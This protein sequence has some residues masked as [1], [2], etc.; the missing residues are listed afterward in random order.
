MAKRYYRKLAMLHKVEAVYGTD[1]APTGMANAIQATDVTFT[2]ME[3]GEEQRDLLQAHFGHSGIILTGLHARLEF[4]VELAG[5]GTAGDVPAWGGL[6]R[7]CGFAE[8]VTEDTDVVY[9]PVSGDFES[10][11]IWYNRDGV[12]HAIVGQRGTVSLQM[13]PARIPRLRFNVLG[14]HGT[15][16]ADTALPTVDYTGFQ[17]PLVVSKANT[18]FALHG[19]SGPTESV[20]IDLGNQVEPRMLIGEEAVVVTDR[21]ASGSAVMEAALLATINWD[22]IA[23]AHTKGALALV[24]GKTE[25]NIIE[26]DAPHVQIGRYTEGNTQGIMNNTLPLMLT[27][28]SAGNDELTITVK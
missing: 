28:S 13:T 18:T 8:T 14:L 12:K 7:T 15:V 26:I 25:G 3:G 10:G 6:L 23:R 27:P 19:Y 1:A 11:T 17:T 24:H 20:S 16:P 2:P 9:S 5:A 22:Q 21:R 4:S